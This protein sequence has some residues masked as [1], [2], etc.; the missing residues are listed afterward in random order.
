MG[1]FLVHLSQESRGNEGL[2]R[3]SVGLGSVLAPL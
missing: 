1:H 3:M 2:P